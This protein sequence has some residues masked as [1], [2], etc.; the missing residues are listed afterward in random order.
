MPPTTPAT[1]PAKII[2]IVYIF[3]LNPVFKELEIIY[4][5]AIY[6][7]PIIPPFN[8]PFF[9]HL[10]A[11]IVLLISILKKEIDIITIGIVVSAI[12]VH[13]S[14]MEYNSIPINVNI[15]DVKTPIINFIY[16]FS[17]MFSKLH[18]SFIILYAIYL[19]LEQWIVV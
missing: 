13:D 5:I 10:R 16:L 15:I 2:I 11:I 12:L 7:P 18:L 17:F 8:I 19:N 3:T 4:R 6:A 14:N 1:I 9:E